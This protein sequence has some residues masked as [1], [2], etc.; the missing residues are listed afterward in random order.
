[1]NPERGLPLIGSLMVL[2]VMASSGI[3]GMV[4]FISEFLVFR[5]SFAVFPTQTLLCMIGTGLTAVY[6]LLLVNRVFFGRLSLPALNLPPVGWFDRTPAMILA[7][8]IVIFGLQP[9]WM[10]R[11]SE[12]TTTA[13]MPTP[14][15]IV[16]HNT[17]LDEYQQ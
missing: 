8:A 11:W 9:A 16:S 14:A 13:F 5:G 17:V 10:L 3:P 1:M 6:F 4:G 7:V 15:A 2:G 12:A